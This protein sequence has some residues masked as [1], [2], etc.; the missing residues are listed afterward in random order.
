LRSSDS[1][2]AAETHKYYVDTIKKDTHRYRQFRKD[3]HMSSDI[4]PSPTCICHYHI[5]IHGPTQTY[6]IYPQ[7]NLP[8]TQK[9]RFHRCA[10]MDQLTNVVL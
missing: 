6:F 1:V 9:K 2:I 3:S 8:T 5:S 4:C 7:W 10:G